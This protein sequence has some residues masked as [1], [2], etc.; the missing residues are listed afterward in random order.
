MANKRSSRKPPNQQ[1]QP[2]K[3]NSTDCYRCDG[4]HKALDC[5]FQNAKCNFC[6]KKGHIAKVCHTRLKLQK[7]QN[8]QMHTTDE[9]DYKLQEYSLFHTLGSRCL[10]LILIS[11]K[12]NTVNLMMELDTGEMLSLISEK[13][14]HNVFPTEPAPQLNTSQAEL[15]TYTGESITITGAIDVEVVYNDQ[16]KQL[17]FLVVEEEGPSLLG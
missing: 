5:K 3:A 12:V 15:K 14:Y 11:L 16:H 9:P 7:F 8:H 17:N 13:T 4:K 1:Q 10:P 6:K 2:Q